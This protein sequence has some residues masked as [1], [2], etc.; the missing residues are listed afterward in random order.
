MSSRTFVDGHELT[1]AKGGYADLISHCVRDEVMP[2]AGRWRQS[3]RLAKIK[4]SASQLGVDR[5]MNQPNRF[6]TLNPEISLSAGHD[7]M[8]V[9]ARRKNGAL[10]HIGA[11][12]NG[13]ACECTCLACDEALIA[14]HGDVREH[15]FAHQSGTQCDHALEAMLHAV[16]AELI[17]QR[18]QFVTP[19][20]HVH[21]AVIGPFGRIVEAINRPAIQV[22]VESVLV[23]KRSP[24]RRPCIVASVKGRALAIR[25]A[26]DHKSCESD[27]RSLAELDQ[28]A[29][30]IDLSKHGLRTLAELEQVLFEADDRKGWLFNHRQQDLHAELLARLTSQAER[31][32][33][34][35]KQALQELAAHQERERQERELRQA[36]AWGAEHDQLNRRAAASVNTSSAS[37]RHPRPAEGSPT[38]EYLTPEGRIWLLHSAHPDIHFRT[39]AS[40]QCALQVLRNHGAVEGTTPEGDAGVFKISPVGWSAASVELAGTWLSVKSVTGQQAAQLEEPRSVQ[41]GQ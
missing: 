41:A 5:A 20:L 38:I 28:A 21:A 33:F 22:P 26:L 15:S 25:I 29:V 17:G 1:L 12:A 24:W 11:V 36:A 23:E 34:E 7:R 39:E 4:P 3:I 9:F 40:V 37:F 27:C 13:K 16:A 14:R 8:V 18:G 31:Q 35:H 10:A 6:F 2:H 19:P 32:W 30:E